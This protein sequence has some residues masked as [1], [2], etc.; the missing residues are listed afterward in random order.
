MTGRVGARP[1]RWIRTRAAQGR[2]GWL[3]GVAVFL[4]L[5][6]PLLMAGRLVEE[7]D[8]RRRTN[9]AVDP[10]IFMQIEHFVRRDDGT[11]EW[12]DL[13]GSS[14]DALTRL[15]AEDPGSI[16]QGGVHF[17]RRLA[18]WAFSTREFASAQV[19]ARAMGQKAFAPVADQ[20]LRREIV[21]YCT[22]TRFPLDPQADYLTHTDMVFDRRLVRGWIENACLIATAVLWMLAVIR[23]RAVFRPAALERRRRRLEAHRCPSCRYDVSVQQRSGIKVCPECGGSWAMP[24]E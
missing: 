22:G 6:A 8:E 19:L 13:D 17:E 7:L 5:V 23:Y 3:T 24:G 12:F 21:A 2:A 11:W 14:A 1:L 15:I 18:G 10:A 20:Q 9:F 4:W 16:V